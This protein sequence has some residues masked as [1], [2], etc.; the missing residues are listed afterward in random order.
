M[1]ELIAHD[2]IEH[3]TLRKWLVFT[4]E[5]VVKNYE[6]IFG[7]GGVIKLNIAI[8]K[9]QQDF[10]EIKRYCQ[11]VGILRYSHSVGMLTM[12]LFESDDMDNFLDGVLDLKDQNGKSDDILKIGQITQQILDDTDGELARIRVK[13]LL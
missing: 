7:E 8:D 2:L 10:Y 12:N 11:F 4:N 13:K 6:A 3:G 1:T 5:D 9:M